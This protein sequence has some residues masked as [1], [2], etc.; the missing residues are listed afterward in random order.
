MRRCLSLLVFAVLGNGC[1]SNH[2][3]D[4][5]GFGFASLVPLPMSVVR[6]PGAFRIAASTTIYVDAASPE[7]EAIG[8]T[9]ADKLNAATGYNI[10]VAASAGLP[11]DGNI[12]LTTSDANPSLGEEGYSLTVTTTSVSIRAANPVGVFRGIQTVLQLLPAEIE[13]TTAQDTPWLISAGTIT[14]RPR[15]GWRGMMLDVARHFFTVPDVKTLIDTMAFYKLNRLHLH[16]SDDQGWRIAIKAFPTLAMIGGLTSV[17]GG[18]GG[19]FSQAEYSDIVSYARQRYITVVPELEMPGHTSA[20]LAS[21]PDLN[22]D[23]NAPPLYTGTAVGFSSLC[24]SKESS[25][26]FAEKVLMELAALTPGPYLH[27]GGD[28]AQ[29]TPV[30]DYIKFIERVQPMVKALGKQLVGWEEVAQAHL[31]PTSIAQHW[32]QSTLTKAAVQQ[33]TKIVMSAASKMYMDMKYDTSTVVGQSWA[34]LIDV[35]TAYSWDPASHVSGISETDI[36]GV[37]APLWTETIRSINDV[38]QMT[39]PRLIGYAEI[40]WSPQASRDWNDYR[41]R[42]AN[43]GRRLTARNVQFYHSPQIDWQ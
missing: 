3:P 37:E 18:P 20:A 7:L 28:E 42:L 33:G 38:Q 29:G 11:G 16:L 34:G 36:L 35:K 15:F 23:G 10:G 17:G 8:R 5:K 2:A 1:E 12:Q 30:A 43:Q 25:Y 9:L 39:F 26:S 31:L 14:D 27:I 24:T 13:T 22:C 4:P 6:A 32:L 21:I 41:V 40:G 19:Y